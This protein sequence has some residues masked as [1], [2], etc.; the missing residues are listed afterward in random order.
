LQEVVIDDPK[1]TIFQYNLGVICSILSSALAEQGRIREAIAC[2]EQARTLYQKLV[3]SSPSDASYKEALV[4]AEHDLAV[5]A[6]KK[7]Q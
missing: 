1:A 4:S 5:L 6:Q 3:D 7:E 2:L